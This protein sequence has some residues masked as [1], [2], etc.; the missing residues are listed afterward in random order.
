M[1][2]EQYGGVLQKNSSLTPLVDAQVDK[3]WKNGTIAALQK[4]WFNIDFSK[5]PNLK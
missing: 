1:T 4:K 2:K 5:I 3:L